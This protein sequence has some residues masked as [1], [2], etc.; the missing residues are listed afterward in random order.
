MKLSSQ[1]AS[2]LTALAFLLFTLT[3]PLPR[4]AVEALGSAGTAAAVSGTGTVCGIVAG[5]RTQGIQ[6]FLRNRT[7]WIR[8][9]NASF[10]SVAGGANFFCGIRSGGSSL[11][12]WDTL[13]GFEPRRLYY[14]ETAPLTDVT[15]GDDQVCAV[16]VNTGI[17]RYFQKW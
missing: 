2:L 15:V 16:V 10:E 3:S 6:C 14:S 13:S 9:S 5:H 7:I 17:A 11:L 1:P 12:C 8:P 4:S